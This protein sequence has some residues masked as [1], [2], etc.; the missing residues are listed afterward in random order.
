MRGFSAVAGRDQL[1]VALSVR[2]DGEHRYRL[3]ATAAASLCTCQVDL[4]L[5]DGQCA[6][7]DMQTCWSLTPPGPGAMAAA[8]FG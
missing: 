7:F 5:R 6:R 4:E 1:I 3:R 2:H 8:D